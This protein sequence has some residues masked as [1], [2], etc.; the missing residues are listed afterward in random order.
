LQIDIARID[1]RGLNVGRM[2]SSRG[3]DAAYR[4]Q[5]Y[6]IFNRGTRMNIRFS[7]LATAM[8]VVAAVLLTSGRSW[9]I[10]NLL[11][12]DKEEWGLK[13]D[14]QVNDTGRDTVT[15]V[16]SLAD[17]GRLKPF[18]SIEVIAMNPETDSQGGH[19]YDVKE[20]IIL[21][22]T[23]DGRRIGQVQIKKEFLDHAQIRILTDHVD[24]QQQHWLANYETPVRRFLDKSP[25]PIASPPGSKVT[26]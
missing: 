5:G 10:Y 9:A 8:L 2:G 14:V 25:A 11:G 6:D 3:T 16:F 17:E 12:P 21:K 1:G 18:Y 4:L 20:K 24:G 23:E 19:A 26:K 13:Y 7:R 15:V 22:P